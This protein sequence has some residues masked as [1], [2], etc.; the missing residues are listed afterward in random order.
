MAVTEDDDHGGG[1]LSYD[2][3]SV[4]VTGGTPRQITTIFAF[5]HKFTYHICI[6]NTGNNSWSQSQNNYRQLYLS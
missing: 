2:D 6:G 1:G 3:D 4:E 5:F